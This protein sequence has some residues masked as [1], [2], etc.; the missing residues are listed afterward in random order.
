MDAFCFIYIIRRANILGEETRKKEKSEQASK[1]AKQL[2]FLDMEDLHYFTQT[3][4]H[5]RKQS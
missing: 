5:H 2:L 3:N 4:T 1:H